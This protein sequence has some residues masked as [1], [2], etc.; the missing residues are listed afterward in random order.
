MQPIQCK[1][2]INEIIGLIV[3][4]EKGDFLSQDNLQKLLNL[5]KGMRFDC[6]DVISNLLVNSKG[7]YID[8][9]NGEFN[10]S[11]NKLN[12]LMKELDELI[13]QKIIVPQDMGSGPAIR[14]RVFYFNSNENGEIEVKFTQLGEFN[15]IDIALQ[16]LS[17][18]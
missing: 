17:R 7:F 11:H 1:N 6:D 18:M 14:H 16:A 10:D 13:V 9:Y 15:S 8:N 2:K 5:I 3:M 4:P 12:S